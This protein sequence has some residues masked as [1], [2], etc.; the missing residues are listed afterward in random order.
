[1][2]PKERIKDFFFISMKDIDDPPELN[3]MISKTIQLLRNNKM[4]VVELVVDGDNLLQRLVRLICIADWTSFYLAIM[5]E[6][7]PTTIPIIMD[8]KG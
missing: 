3:I 1:M 2:F 7:D 5:N 8:L 6:V 4:D